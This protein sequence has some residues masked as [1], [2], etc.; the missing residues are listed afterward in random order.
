MIVHDVQMHIYGVYS[1]EMYYWNATT[2]HLRLHCTA[3]VGTIDGF[4]H[5]LRSAFSALYSDCVPNCY[6]TRTIARA[7]STRSA[8][9][10]HSEELLTAVHRTNTLQ[11]TWYM[12]TLYMHACTHCRC[13]L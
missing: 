3:V 1:S 13:A 12:C 2:I 6:V 11:T 8:S 9:E 10:A 7:A 4:T 5:A